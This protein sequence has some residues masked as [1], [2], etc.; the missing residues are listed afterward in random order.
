MIKRNKTKSKSKKV[1]KRNPISS[2][3]MDSVDY[4]ELSSFVKEFDKQLKKNSS[5][6]VY[7]DLGYE[8]DNILKYSL[9]NSN[10]VSGGEL[11]LMPLNS[12]QK[13]V[14]TG[15]KNRFSESGYYLDLISVF[16]LTLA[17]IPKTVTFVDTGN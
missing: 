4:I 6:D 9:R 3:K 7:Y 8:I 16:K 13:T 17:E 5:Y 2:R 12:F 11:N 14:S 15:I 1:T 10:L